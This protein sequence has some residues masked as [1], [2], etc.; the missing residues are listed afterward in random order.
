MK[1]LKLNDL[2]L[3]R[4][5]GR[6]KLHVSVYESGS[7]DGLGAFIRNQQFEHTERSRRY[8][9]LEMKERPGDIHRLVAGLLPTLPSELPFLWRFTILSTKASKRHT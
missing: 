8:L 5:I 9:N 4:H 2:G 1:L 3:V 6:T 7:W